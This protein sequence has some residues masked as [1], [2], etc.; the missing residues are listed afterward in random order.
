MTMVDGDVWIAT[1]DDG[2]T[3]VRIDVASRHVT[4]SHP[5]VG[6]L[7][8][9]AVNNGV[10]WV[11]GAL[12]LARIDVDD[13]TVMERRSDPAEMFRG[14]TLWQDVL[15]VLDRGQDYGQGHLAPPSTEPRVIFLDASTG[16]SVGRPLRLDVPPYDVVVAGGDTA[17]I[18]SDE[19]KAL[20]R[21]RR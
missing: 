5:G 16:A 19:A 15:W 7:D 6:L 14:M 2:G 10:A 21:V 3:L 13:M 11:H 1:R 12:G 18:S 8:A 9:V 17:W 4:R 20:L